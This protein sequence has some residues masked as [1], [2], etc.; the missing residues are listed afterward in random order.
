MSVRWWRNQLTE[1]LKAH[2]GASQ[3]DHASTISCRKQ[4]RQCAWWAQAWLG[5]EQYRTQQCCQK[6]GVSVVAG[7]LK[8]SRSHWNHVTSTAILAMARNL[9]STLEGKQLFTSW[10]SRQSRSQEKHNKSRE[11]DDHRF[12]VIA[13]VASEYAWRWRELKWGKKRRREIVSQRYCRT[14]RRWVQR[15][16]VGAETSWFKIWTECEMSGHVIPNRQGS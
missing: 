7:T 3:L 4:Q 10:F 14:R 16:C 13:L 2:G 6:K 9:V 12:R 8:F 5:I 11:S 15:S 1:P